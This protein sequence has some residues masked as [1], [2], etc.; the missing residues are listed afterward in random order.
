M[1]SGKV[2]KPAAKKAK[3]VYKTYV[4]QLRKESGTNQ[5]DFW[6][7][8]GVT[9][10]AGSRFENGRKMPMPLTLLICASFEGHITNDPKS[11][12]TQGRLFKKLALEKGTKK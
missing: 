3:P 6:T 1:N 4:Q 7:R 12:Y 2:S 11:V 5:T 9:Q 8:F 10:S